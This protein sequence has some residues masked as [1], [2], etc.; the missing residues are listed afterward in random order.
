MPLPGQVNHEP[1]LGRSEKVG[2]WM[3][4]KFTSLLFVKR[5]LLVPNLLYES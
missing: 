3:S 4:N 2:S 1:A 5:K